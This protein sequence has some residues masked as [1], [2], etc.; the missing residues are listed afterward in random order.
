MIG[1]VRAAL[2]GEV[3][4]GLVG[5]VGDRFH[6]L[7][8]ERHRLR[9]GKRHALGVK[10]IGQTH[11]AQ[12]DGPVA[13]VRALGRLGRVEIDVDDIVERADR[14][15]DGLAQ[16]EVIQR[17][18]R[19]QM[20]I[21]DDRAQ[22]AHRGFVRGSIQ[23]YFRAEIR[24]VDHADVILRRTHIA[25]VLEGDPG[26]ARLEQHREHLFPQIE[27]LDLL[28]EDLAV[29][30]QLLV[31]GVALLELL[32]VGFVQIR[33]LVGAEQGPLLAR[34]HPLHE[35]VGN[36]VGRVHVVGAAAIVAGVLAQLEELEDVVVPALEIGAAGTLAL[37]ALVDRDQL[38]VV[39]LQ[40]RD[41]ALR[42][43]VGAAN[44]GAGA[45]DRRPG[46]AQAARPLGQVSVL[47]DAALE[48]AL[49]RVRRRSRGST[50]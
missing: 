24:R 25:G 6:R 23:S 12:A 31:L 39:E 50:S 34:L 2:G 28:A 11:H 33:G 16:L 1:G 7:V 5:V 9:G 40:E 32:A 20:G 15:A 41:D 21:E 19:Q 30:G 18:V 37:A 44:V 4:A 48:D 43:A 17:A 29:R 45:A 38:V 36:P 35:Q 49:D 46:A 42:L 3:G 8:V 13:Q 26:M 22:I 27:R 10:R 47:G 14:H